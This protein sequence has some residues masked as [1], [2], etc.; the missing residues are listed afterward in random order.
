MVLCGCPHPSI[1]GPA[2]VER[3]LHY[4]VP[5]VMGQEGCLRRA[6]PE[7]PPPLTRMKKNQKEEE[8]DGTAMSLP[9][10]QILVPRTIG[11]APPLSS[12]GSCDKRC[13]GSN[14]SSRDFACRTECHSTS[15]HG[16]R[17]E[18]KTAVSCPID[19][20]SQ[21]PNRTSF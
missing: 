11:S 18:D 15:E 12:T 21:P 13:R 10:L 9:G 1:L 7:A 8:G 6:F 20:G 2:L 16:S 3:R 19:L 4:L 14:F 17:G 5:G